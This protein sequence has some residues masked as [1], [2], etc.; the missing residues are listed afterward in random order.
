MTVLKKELRM[1]GSYD[2]A[3]DV[4]AIIEQSV[5]RARLEMQ[6]RLGDDIITQLLAITYSA[7]PTTADQRRRALANLVEIELVRA[8]LLDILPII[9]KDSSGGVSEDWNDNGVFRAASADESRRRPPLG[10]DL[11]FVNR[12]ISTLT[13]ESDVP[14]DLVFTTLRGREHRKAKPRLDQ[15]F[16]RG[17][18]L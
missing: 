7:N 16:L 4:H 1:S 18:D 15:D 13:G 2:T 8:R 12:A 14:D 10:A 6:E 17:R 3:A 11:D 5:L 9:F